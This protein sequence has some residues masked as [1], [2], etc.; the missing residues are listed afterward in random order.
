MNL[1]QIGAWIEMHDPQ[2]YMTRVQHE[3]IVSCLQRD[4]VTKAKQMLIDW[5]IPQNVLDGR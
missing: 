3:I 2:R 1:F 5:K 4:D